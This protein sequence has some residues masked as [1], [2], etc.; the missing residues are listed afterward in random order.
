MIVSAVWVLFAAITLAANGLGEV[1]FPGFLPFALIAFTFISI[2]T[3]TYWIYT[4]SPKRIAT[5]S[6]M[7]SL[8]G[9]KFSALCQNIQKLYAEFPHTFEEPSLMYS[10][11]PHP[12][13]FTFGTR[14]NVCIQMTSGLL[15]TDESETFKAI[16]LHEMGHIE[17]R[18]VGKAY[19]AISAI[20]TMK[21]ILPSIL[22]IFV[23][24]DTYP[25][26][27]ALFSGIPASYIVSQM[28]LSYS[29]TGVIAVF[30][31]IFGVIIIALRNQIIRLREFYADSRVVEWTKSSTDLEKTLEK[32]RTS[33]SRFEL[34]RRFHPSI[35]ERIDALRDNSRLFIPNLWIAFSAGFLYTFFAMEIPFLYALLF[36]MAT[37]T[38]PATI[39]GAYPFALISTVLIFGILMFAISSEFHRSIL[40]ET[41]ANRAG[42]FSSAAVL[43]IVKVSVVF[44]L[45]MFCGYLFPNMVNLASYLDEL[46]Y[47]TTATVGT[48]FK[49]WVIGTIGFSMAVI[50]L[51]FV[52]SMLVRR[53]L[54]RKDARRKFYLASILASILYVLITQTYATVRYGFVLGFVVVVYVIIKIIDRRLCCPC[55]SNKLMISS[56][57]LPDCPRCK[58][59]L[60]SWAVYS[61]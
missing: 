43:N 8:Q 28:R 33:I 18:D 20:G 59:P 58:S 45:G 40:R 25:T 50:F 21:V 3:L 14:K 55:C 36:T 39:P 53:S 49:A 56:K 48:F 23:L 37:E 30:L 54:F 41:L 26:L 32:H 15:L 61:F 16:L 9:G 51:W 19:L 1:A 10:M 34:L 52:G 29:L 13:A 44:S 2:P 42:Y 6:E 11:D 24:G 4:R 38:R 47:W 57:L 7:K 31:I 5:K 35:E 12:S 22:A 17:N 60:Y 27:G 46:A